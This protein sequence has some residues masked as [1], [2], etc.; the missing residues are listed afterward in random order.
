[1]RLSIWPRPA[2]S[3]AGV[4]FSGHCLEL[5]AAYEEVIQEESMAYWAL[6]TCEDGSDDLKFAA[7]GDGGL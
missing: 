2:S 5:L 6:Y 1:M 3:M 7:S 4:S